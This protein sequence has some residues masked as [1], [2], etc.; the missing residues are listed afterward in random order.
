MNRDKGGYFSNM[1]DV[2]EI[3]YEIYTHPVIVLCRNCHGE[4]HFGVRDEW[5]YEDFILGADCSE[6][7]NASNVKSKKTRPVFDPDVHVD[8]DL[9]CGR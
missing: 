1:R 7:P 8:F 6:L 5:E 4:V 2:S 9:V 3:A